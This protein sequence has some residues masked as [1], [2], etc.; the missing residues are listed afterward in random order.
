MR[1][2]ITAD[3]VT[4]GGWTSHENH[5]EVAKYYLNRAGIPNARVNR[6]YSNDEDRLRNEESREAS[7]LYKAQAYLSDARAAYTAGLGARLAIAFVNNHRQVINAVER[8]NA[9][10]ALIGYCQIPLPPDLRVHEE[11]DE[12]RTE[13]NKEN[14]IVRETSMALAGVD[15]GWR[16]GKNGRM[17]YVN[18]YARN[19]GPRD[20]VRRSVGYSRA[21]YD[22]EQKY[23]YRASTRGGE[24]WWEWLR[25]EKRE[26]TR[27]STRQLVKTS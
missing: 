6:L 4:G 12:S 19:Y 9:L 21:A 10:L 24:G 26:L 15:R 17:R 22:D 5:G 3:V 7:I 18:P 14:W 2:A 1:G 13:K 11:V 16:R 23:G 27:E 25:D 8:A 20:S